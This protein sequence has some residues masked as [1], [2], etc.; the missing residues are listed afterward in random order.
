VPNLRIFQGRE[1]ERS[2]LN[3]W[4]ADPSVS[5]IGIRGEGGIGK[6]MLMA[7]VFAESQGFAGK[8]WVD[9][10]TGTSIA[11]LAERAL[12]EF[13]ALPEQVRSLE[14][15]DLIRGLLRQLQQGR[16]LLAIDNLESVLTTEGNWRG[17]YEDFL[18]GFQNLGSES[19]LQ[20]ENIPKNILVGGTLAG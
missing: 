12:Q 14:E 13:G 17:G 10:R 7:K 18:D 2:D 3:T 1:D 20:G 11:A 15:K 5:M 4:L 6:S 9:V 8:F 19:V 16:Y